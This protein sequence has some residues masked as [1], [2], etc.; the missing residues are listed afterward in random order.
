[1][2]CIHV[3][4]LKS[5]QGIGVEFNTNN[6]E[7]VYYFCF[8]TIYSIIQWIAK[9]NYIYNIFMDISTFTIALKVKEMFYWHFSTLLCIFC[10]A[11]IFPRFFKNI[12]DSIRIIFNMWNEFKFLTSTFHFFIQT[13][14]HGTTVTYNNT[15]IKQQ[16]H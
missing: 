9:C 2:H 8:V 5:I 14:K 16:N 13:T 7:N 15:I 11:F 3:F 6:H 12:Q 4:M 10:F 1:M